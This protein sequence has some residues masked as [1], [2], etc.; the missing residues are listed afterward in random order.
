MSSNSLTKPGKYTAKIIDADVWTSKKGDPIAVLMFEFADETGSPKRRSWFGSLN[1]G[2]REITVETLVR[3]G[4]QGN[5]LSDLNKGKEALVEGP[6]EIVIEN[7]ANPSKGGEIQDRVKYINLPGGG[8]FRDRMSQDDAV[9]LCSG[10]NLAA[11]FMQ[12]RQ[13]VGKVKTPDASRSLSAE[14]KEFGDKLPF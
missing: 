9:R 14:E 7:E 6:Y 8:G 12:A 4:F 2:A 3:C 10:L 13:K 11:D 1:G 5:S